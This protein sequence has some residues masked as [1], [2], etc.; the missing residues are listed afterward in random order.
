MKQQPIIRDERY[1]AVE[2]ASYKV[3][4]IIMLFGAFFIG[5]VR[6]ALFHQNVWDLLGL[7]LLGSLAATIYQIRK[8]VVP[9]T[10]KTLILMLVL[11]LVTAVVAGLI[12]FWI[13]NT[14]F[15]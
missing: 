1:Y 14:F 15:K 13:K 8:K 11:C 4:F 3:G 6:S 12:V 9:Y 5:I 7:A 10:I 2:N